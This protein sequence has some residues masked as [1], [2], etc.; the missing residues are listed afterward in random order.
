MATIPATS[1]T[2]RC[3]ED[4]IPKP[5]IQKIINIRRKSDH[6]LSNHNSD[7]ENEH[8]QFT[9]TTT[10]TT[11]PT[12]P[13][14]ISTPEKQQL[15]EQKSRSESRESIHSTKEF[16]EELQLENS[17]YHVH[18]RK[19]K[20]N[21]KSEIQQ[22]QQ[23]QQQQ[24]NSSSSSSSLKQP[25]PRNLSDTSTESGIASQASSSTNNNN[26]NDHNLRDE[27]TSNYQ[28]KL[29]QQNKLNDSNNNN[30]K[31]L[32]PLHERMIDIS[33]T[34]ITDKE[35]NED[36]EE[37]IALS[38]NHHR[39]S[40]VSPLA[41][42]S[43]TNSS[44]IR[45]IDHNNNKSNITKE[46]TS[47][48]LYPLN[49]KTNNVPKLA[50][51]S[52]RYQKQ[53][54]D[55]GDIF[56]FEHIQ[57][58]DR[59]YLENH[60]HRHQQH[61]RNHN[62]TYHHHHS[63]LTL[64]RVPSKPSSLYIDTKRERG[65]VS[66]R[67][68]RSSS[69]RSDIYRTNN[70]IVGSRSMFF[71]STNAMTKPSNRDHAGNNSSY[72]HS[73]ATLP[74]RTSNGGLKRNET[75]RSIAGAGSSVSQILPSPG[76]NTVARSVCSC[77]TLGGG[78][79]L[80]DIKEEMPIF[81]AAFSEHN[82]Y[83]YEQRVQKAKYAAVFLVVL[84]A[85]CL[86]VGGFLHFY[87]GYFPEEFVL[88]QGDVKL[89]SFS[90]M[91]CRGIRGSADD[92]QLRLITFKSEEGSRSDTNRLKYTRTKENF[93]IYPQQVWKRDFYLLDS[94]QVE[95][96]IET[97]SLL[98]LMVFKGDNSM[99]IWETRKESDSYLIRDSCCSNKY[100]RRDTIKFI[101]STTDRYYIVLYSRTEIIPVS[102][103][104]FRI[105]FNR[106]T[107]DF[108][109]TASSCKT[110]NSG[111]ECTVDYPLTGDNR[112]AVEVPLIEN[113]NEIST[114][115]TVKYLCVAREWMYFLF[116]TGVFLLS[117]LLIIAL[118]LLVIR[119]CIPS[120]RCFWY[121]KD[122]KKNMNNLDIVYY[123]NHGRAMSE[124]YLD[125]NFDSVSR[126]ISYAPSRRSDAKSLY[127]HNNHNDNASLFSSS[128]QPRNLGRHS[129]R[130]T[131]SRA[132]TLPRNAFAS[133]SSNSNSVAALYK[134]DFV[135][136][137]RADSGISIN[138]ELSPSGIS[139]ITT[140]EAYKQRHPLDERNFHHMQQKAFDLVNGPPVKNLLKDR[141]R[142][143]AGDRDH[144]HRRYQSQPNHGTPIEYNPDN[145]DIALPDRD[146]GDH[147][148]H[149]LMSRD[150][151]RQP[152]RSQSARDPRNS[153]RE[154]TSSDLYHQQKGPPFVDNDD[155][156]GNRR[157]KQIDYD[158]REIFI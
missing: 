121:R 10:T 76:Y 38:E 24:Q 106:L 70:S 73:C 64:D 1:T 144:H 51:P 86:T 153:S 61:Y 150:K 147:V 35:L 74:V 158:D 105:Q 37:T 14:S 65:T 63:F 128:R 43:P 75:F 139:S 80:S 116:F 125:Q 120:K 60:Q 132:S 100:P 117:V 107:Y 108:S 66:E 19:K 131:V 138:P 83:V 90:S 39:P 9:T 59:S 96:T 25:K 49:N 148:P 155:N 72:A 12:D 91:F 81:D 2:E 32:A 137:E 50:Y 102:V 92:G 5:T 40:P 118:Y 68:L 67:Y 77:G 110:K 36:W 127:N 122:L 141:P 99:S 18:K 56:D 152:K 111:E 79:G 78:P 156:N 26:S 88:N 133:T 42:S 34:T 41:L 124:L 142:S 55:Q 104:L 119:V 20:K 98:D 115:A 57:Q 29:Q 21:T 136:M 113:S 112:V 46:A 95:I 129:N 11:P 130:P 151:R 123:D 101:A 140:Q 31:E 71:S 52:T 47:Q 103:K 27:D 13:E 89:L 94:S 44:P 8:I 134:D 6:A 135:D 30:D 4:I 23:Q 157:I 145:F 69:S 17:T 53:Q 3:L 93:K 84:T 7:T 15:A 97:D 54:K 22:Q 62:N 143:L 28:Q 114:S 109:R 126:A 58:H 16:I 146:V 45:N 48:S 87:V 85:I 82:K 154:S 149:H 33:D